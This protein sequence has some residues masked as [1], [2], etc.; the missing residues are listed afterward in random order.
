MTLKYKE[1]S[2]EELSQLY[3]K[4][5]LLWVDK[6]LKLLREKAYEFVDWDNLLQEIEDM[7]RSELRACISYM[8]VILEHMYKWDFYRDKTSAGLRDGGHGWIKS[9][10]NSRYRLNLVIERNPSLKTKIESMVE[11]AWKE[12]KPSIVES[13][14]NLGVDIEIE[15][16]PEKCPYSYRQAMERNLLEE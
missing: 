7:G 6:N 3:D 4:D 10:K 9:I 2:K 14:Y 11:E 5:Y 16:L 12:A 15:D 1:F 8:A 13:L